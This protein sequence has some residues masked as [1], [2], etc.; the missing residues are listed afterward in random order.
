MDTDLGDFGDLGDLSQ[1]DAFFD[2]ETQEDPI[3]D[4]LAD[5][6]AFGPTD[7]DPMP[8]VGGE[9][10]DTAVVESP[11]SVTEAGKRATSTP[12]PGAEV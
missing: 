1:F 10:L 12:V 3:E 8:T 4:G 9:S 11:T 7:I 5:A 2:L 6:E